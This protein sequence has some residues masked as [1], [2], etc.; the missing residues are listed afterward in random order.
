[1]TSIPHTTPHQSGTH[2]QM[3]DGSLVTVHPERV[4][5]LFA[6]M[7]EAAALKRPMTTDEMIRFAEAPPL[8]ASDAE[9]AAIQP[10]IETPVE[11]VPKVLRT[12]TAK[13]T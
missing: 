3:P 1:M 9:D 11:D 6:A 5:E 4:E 8:S 12:R 10:P 13:E 7:R 2:I